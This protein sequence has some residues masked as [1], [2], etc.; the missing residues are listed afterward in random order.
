MKAIIK[1][2]LLGLALMLAVA[3][4]AQATSFTDYVENLAVDHM[5]RGQAFSESSP[6]SYYVGLLTAGCTDSAGGTEVSGGSYARVSVSRAAAS[7]KGT[8]GS[9]TGASSGTNGTI[10][11]AAA[12]TFPAPTAN[13]GVITHFGI[14]DASTSGN[15]VVCQSLTASKTVNNG[16]AAPAFAVDALTIQID[17]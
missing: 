17:N 9:A 1:S 3:L 4:P 7:W 15:L 6:A 14:Y 2:F 13:W 5:F 10:S 8:H 16:D 11:N 12:I